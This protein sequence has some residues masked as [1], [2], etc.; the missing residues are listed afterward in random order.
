MDVSL[1]TSRLARRVMQESTGGLESWNPAAPDCR[2]MTVGREG[3]RKGGER[4]GE[5]EGG[6]RERE[7]GRERGR[8][9]GER[10]REG[11]NWSVSGYSEDHNHVPTIV[12]GK[13]C[14]P[15]AAPPA[16]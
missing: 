6:R 11:R 4:E 9:G 10:E 5:R 12:H 8:E 16:Q 1:S 7:R 3:G 2:S 13:S 15:V 14:L